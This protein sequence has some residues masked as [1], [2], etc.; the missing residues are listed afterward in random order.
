MKA[1]IF[2]KSNDLELDF[3]KMYFHRNEFL[4]LS[5]SFVNSK[6][7]HAGFSIFFNVLAVF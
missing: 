3:R 5:R 1:L 4:K 6:S 2:P 7:M